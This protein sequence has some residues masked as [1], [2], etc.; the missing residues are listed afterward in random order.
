MNHP[1]DLR[2]Y[3]YLTE[4]AVEDYIEETTFEAVDEPLLPTG[5]MF[6]LLEMD[7][8]DNAIDSSELIL[9]NG[10]WNEVIEERFI[11][12]SSTDLENV[13]WRSLPGFVSVIT[14]SQFEGS[15]NNVNSKYDQLVEGI[16]ELIQKWS[17]LKENSGNSD[18][19]YGVEQGYLLA[20]SSL[21]DLL[22]K[23]DK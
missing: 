1:N 11:R 13:A 20:S 21:E 7:D 8:G 15:S 14:E 5:D 3:I 2:Q 12:I 4:Q 23:V 10:I 19:D 18:I 6:Y 17:Y 9:D 16:R 22:R